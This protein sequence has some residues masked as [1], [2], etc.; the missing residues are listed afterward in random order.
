[1]ARQRPA[2]GVGFGNYEAA[3]PQYR[4]MS[5][6]FALGHAHN[7]YLNLLSETGVAGLAAYLLF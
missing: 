5:W 6:P 4:L 3:Y 1:M 2:L 7:Y